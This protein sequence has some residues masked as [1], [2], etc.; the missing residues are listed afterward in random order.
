MLKDAK[1]GEKTTH[2]TDRMESPMNDLDVS[3][4]KFANTCARKLWRFLAIRRWTYDNL[5]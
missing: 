4:V 1:T 3:A 2:G 5:P